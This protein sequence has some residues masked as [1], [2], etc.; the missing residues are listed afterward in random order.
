MAVQE[1][2]TS[3]IDAATD[4]GLVGWKE[5]PIDGYA[6]ATMNSKPGYYGDRVPFPDSAA[7]HALRRPTKWPSCSRW[8]IPRELAENPG[9]L[10]MKTRGYPV[11]RAPRA[12]KIHRKFAALASLT[13]D[14]LEADILRFA[15]QFGDLGDESVSDGFTLSTP[16]VPSWNI[17]GENLL[18]WRN[19][20]HEV[21]AL[22]QLWDLVQH[23]KWGKLGQHF[24]WEDRPVRITYFLALDRGCLSTNPANQVDRRTP[25]RNDSEGRQVGDTLVNEATADGAYLL[26]ELPELRSSKTYLRAAPRVFLHER[27][28]RALHGKASP[29]LLTQRQPGH[30][31]LVTPHNLLA[32]IYL[33]LAREMQ[34]EA[35]ALVECANPCCR[36]LIPY[37]ERRTRIYCCDSCRIAAHRA[38]RRA[39]DGDSTRSGSAGAPAA[40]GAG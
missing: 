38:R 24:R 25:T 29:Q 8:L 34:G 20:I 26:D 15:D 13:G 16:E 3:S 23:E 5:V 7:R 1:A 40:A 37:M 21:A 22:V 18:G 14:R 33:R 10:V 36:S 11:L 17:R 4:G 39:A 9:R 2:R 19:Q 31:L 12:S 6:W 27:I 35:A 28:N 32:A 30:D